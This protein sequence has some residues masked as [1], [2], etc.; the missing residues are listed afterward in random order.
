MAL[1]PLGERPLS[2]QPP[3]G[4][5]PFALGFRPFFSLAALSGLILMLAWLFLWRSGDAPDYYGSIGWHSHE[6]LF[7]FTSAIIAGFLLTAVR[8]WTG[9]DTPIGKPLAMLALLWLLAR[10]APFVPAL[11]PAGIALL[12]LAF[13]PLLLVAIYRPL[14]SAENRV[15]RIF[16]PLVAAMALANLLVHLALL[17]I[18]QTERLG[19]HLMINL[20]LLLITIVSARVIPFFTQ[21]AVSGSSPRFSKLREQFVFGA[22]GLWILLDL[23]T[24]PGWLL[25]ITAIAVAGSQFW[26]FL[27]WHHRGI[28]RLPILWVLYSGL[29]WLVL[30]FILKGLSGI[31]LFPDNLAI[32]ALTAGAI[33]VLTF[34]MMA[35]VSLGHTGRDINPPAVIGYS[36]MLLNLASLIRVF[37]P[38][39]HPDAY[40]QWIMLSGSGWAASFLLFA[41]YYLKLLV[42]PRIDGRAG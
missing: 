42:T 28:W 41:I 40:L 30:G 38:V 36:F 17:G 9:I 14:V 18:T 20:T 13:L 22:L 1:I 27:D 21:K 15:N 26:R 2:P 24:A 25:S 3:R 8:N 32:H 39:V 5:V 35:R 34:G 12:D 31:G 33:G 23:L 37:A 6:M 29:L 16:L 4:L 19:T 11:P 10:L 7:G